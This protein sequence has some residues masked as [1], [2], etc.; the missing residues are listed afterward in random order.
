MQKK[1]D[2]I[3]YLPQDFNVSFEYSHVNFRR[4]KLS[5]TKVEAHIFC[6]NSSWHIILY[7]VYDNA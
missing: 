2:V 4:T 7:E 6:S 1:D 3:I 5:K